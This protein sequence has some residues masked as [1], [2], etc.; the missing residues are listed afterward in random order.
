M[1]LIGIEKLQRFQRKHTIAKDYIESW[2]KAVESESW[3]NPDDLRNR[4]SSIKLLGQGVT[5]F[6]VLHN[7]FRLITKFYFKRGVVLICWVGTHSE[8]NQIN[9]KEVCDD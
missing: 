6:K 1:T 8:Y 3:E 2:H 4:F 9:A 5:V 7:E